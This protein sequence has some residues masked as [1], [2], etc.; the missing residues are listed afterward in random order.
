MLYSD[1]VSWTEVGLFGPLHA[2]AVL[3]FKYEARLI[4]IS[5][6]LRQLTPDPLVDRIERK[7]NNTLVKGS[8]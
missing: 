2:Q 6:V 1:A 7:I 3:A 4:W 5:D 8:T